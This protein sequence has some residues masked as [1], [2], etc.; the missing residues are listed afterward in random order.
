V[1][2][3]TKLLL[4]ALAG[5]AGTLARYGLAGLAQRWFGSEFPWGTMLVNLVGCLLIGF[6]WALAENRWPIGGAARVVLFVGF[7]GA[8][9]T[10]SSFVL[11]AAELFRVG[12]VSWGLVNIAGQNVLGLALFLVGYALA[13]LL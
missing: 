5:A 9:T 7:M 12:Q 3:V 8:F 6:F 11:E 13:R 2:L 10:F 4:L 1:S